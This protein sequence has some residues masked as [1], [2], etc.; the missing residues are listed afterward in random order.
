MR[1]FARH[2]DRHHVD[3]AALSMLPTVKTHTHT[4]A[5]QEMTHTQQD[6]NV[7]LVWQSLSCPDSQVPSRKDLGHSNRKRPLL[8]KAHEDREV[9]LLHSWC[10]L[11]LSGSPSR[12]CGHY[13]PVAS[14]SWSHVKVGAYAFKRMPSSRGSL[15]NR[16]Y[17]KSSQTLRM[18]C[19]TLVT[20]GGSL[21]TLTSSDHAVR[22]V[23]CCRKG[24]SHG[25]KLG[26]TAWHRR[27]EVLCSALSCRTRHRSS[28]DQSRPEGAQ[29]TKSGV[30]K[31]SSHV[32]CQLCCI[33]RF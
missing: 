3:S 30:G 22:H 29:H 11:V 12:R 10:L 14:G 31:A 7:K 18:T 4:Q 27:L 25:G 21:L 26:R 33:S 6:N 16:S 23:L 32:A 15:L 17:C 2:L 28:A 24:H 9:C 13:L 5:R 1:C 8:L 19:G 20:C